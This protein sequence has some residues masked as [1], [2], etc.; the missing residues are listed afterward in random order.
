MPR[1]ELIAPTSNEPVSIYTQQ[2]P[3]YDT[4]VAT[5]KE[6]FRMQRGGMTRNFMMR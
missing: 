5:T 6:S 3:I 4:R 1:I 2:R